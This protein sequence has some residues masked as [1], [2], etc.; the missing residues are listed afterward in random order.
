MHNEPM[1]IAQMIV[2]LAITAILVML[3][4]AC[5][6]ESSSPKFDPQLSQ[7]PSIG[8]IGSMAPHLSRGHDDSIVMSWIEPSGEGYA[9]RFAV[10]G[11]DGWGEQRTVASGEDWF[12]NWA[13]FPTVVPVSKDTWGAHWLVRQPA[14]GYAYDVHLSLSHDQGDTWSESMLA[15]TDNTESEHG[16]VSI[17]PQ[18]DG[19]GFIYLDGRKQVN[20]YTEDPNETGMTL[21]AASV[22]SVGILQNEQ[23]VDSLICDCCQTDVAMSAEGP[24]AIYRNRTEDEIR[25]IYVTR[26]VNGQWTQG[27]P[28]NNDGWE[29]PGCPVNGPE[30]FAHGDDVAAAW[31][32]AANESP[33]VKF[34]RSTNSGKTFSA[35]LDIADGETLGHIGMTVD[36]NGDAW[37]VWQSPVGDGEVALTLRRVSAGDQLSPMHTFTAKGEAAAFSVPQIA[38]QGDRLILAWTQGEYGETQIVS[39][40]MSV[41]G[42]H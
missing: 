31:F 17:Y 20:E 1:N 24:V 16:F 3:A 32:T 33:K 36:M 37:I 8:A 35:P 9:L 29:I 19:F 34:V 26:K 41:T 27:L 5:S 18:D 25:D 22:N 6:Q 13:D 42:A 12:V 7:L 28:I 2:R 14:G 30:I 38:A 4:A 10:L 40:Q 21:R 11:D 23:L 39:A 15:H